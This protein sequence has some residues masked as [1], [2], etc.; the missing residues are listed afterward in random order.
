ME[1]WH[2]GPVVLAVILFLLV[3]TVIERQIETAFQRVVS[4][5]L[6]PMLATA[7]ADTTTERELVNHGLEHPATPVPS[8]KS[9]QCTK[10]RSVT[11]IP[12]PPIDMIG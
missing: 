2:C 12:S 3:G 10:S 5:H 8:Q 4:R 1:W 11:N 9:L 7:E 6:R